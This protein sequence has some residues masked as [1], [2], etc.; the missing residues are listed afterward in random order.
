VFGVV[1]T[2]RVVDR[3][4]SCLRIEVVALLFLV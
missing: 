3:E 1:S 4:S 2:F